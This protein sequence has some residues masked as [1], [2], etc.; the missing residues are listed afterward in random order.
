MTTI[1]LDRPWQLG[2]PIASGSFGCV[3]EAEADD[4]SAAVVK[5]VPKAPGDVDSGM[6]R[7][8]EGQTRTESAETFEVRRRALGA[9]CESDYLPSH[10]ETGVLRPR[11]VSCIVRERATRTLAETTRPV[12]KPYYHKRGVDPASGGKNG[13]ANREGDCH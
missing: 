11:V 8:F 13:E 5:L 12:G 4:G 3:H 6:Y 2:K 1:N 9:L 7:A 10:D